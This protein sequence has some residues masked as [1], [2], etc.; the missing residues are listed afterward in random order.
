MCVQT[1]G[2]VNIGS[3]QTKTAGFN[4]EGTSNFENT[5]TGTSF[6]GPLTGNSSTATKIRSITNSN[7]VQ[8]TDTQTLTNKSLTSPTITGVIFF[9][10]SRIDLEPADG[11]NAVIQLHSDMG[12]YTINAQHTNGDYQIYDNDSGRSVFRYFKA[13]Q[14]TTFNGDFNIPENKHYKIDGIDVLHDDS[15]SA[16][17]SFV[18]NARILQNL[19]SSKDGLFINYMST[20]S[21]TNAHCRFYSGGNATERMFIDATGDIGI[22]TV[23]PTEK[24]EVNGNINITTGNEYKINGTA[25]VHSYNSGTNITIDASTKNI[26]LNSPLLGISD[27]KNSGDT[28]F[29]RNNVQICKVG[30]NG[31]E[32]LNSKTFFG[33]IEGQVGPYIIQDTN[34]FDQP[35][36][37][38]KA[39]TGGD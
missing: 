21:A 16:V 10:G 33:D 28:V 1:D 20:Q 9:T 24:L 8:L 25:I 39:F 19:N 15:I 11:S 31:F 14:S 7:I 17:K 26:N 5:V 2:K 32:M 29:T 4:V 34:N 12:R 37:S 3:S 27:I 23:N 18:L 6:V 36:V 38:Y 13:T 30:I 35:I 22:N